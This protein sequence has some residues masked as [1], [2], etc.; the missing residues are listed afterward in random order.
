MP[1]TTSPTPVEVVQPTSPPSSTGEKDVQMIAA[2]IGSLVQPMA[3]AQET[4]AVETTKQTQIIAD[5]TH[6]TYRWFFG[7]GIGVL[8]LAAV[9]LF[10]DKDQVTTQLIVA[11]FSF[12]GGLGIGRVSKK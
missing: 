12:L 5:S 1:D 7:I 6:K 9:A 4:A 11:M 3:Q 10:K 8:V 2:I